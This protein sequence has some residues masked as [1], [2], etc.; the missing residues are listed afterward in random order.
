LLFFVAYPSAATLQFHN[1]AHTGVN[2]AHFSSALGQITPIPSQGYI[3]SRFQSMTRV[4]AAVPHNLQGIAHHA[5]N[6]SGPQPSAHNGPMMV[7]QR[8][9]I[10]TISAATVA[11]SLLTGGS[12]RPVLMTGVGVTTSPWVSLPFPGETSTNSISQ[13]QSMTRPAQSTS[14]LG[15]GKMSYFD[16]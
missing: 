15:A 4:F 3:F 8:S 6:S 14:T 10:S 5:Q 1:T 7:P 9:T 2:Q 11:H 12:D 13:S 16:E